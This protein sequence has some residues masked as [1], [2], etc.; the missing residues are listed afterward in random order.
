MKTILR[1][2]VIT[3]VLLV[4][5][6]L[7]V[8]APIML[9]RVTVKAA[10]VDSAANTITSTGEGKITVTPDVAY[11]NLGVISEGKNLSNTKK[12]NATK[13]AKIM[14]SLKDLGI[15]EKDIKT[16]EYSVNPK[17][18]YNEK[19]GASSINGY[20][21]SNTV[22]VTVVDIDKTDNLLD[23]VVESGSNNIN[24]II[25][26]VKDEASIYNQALELAV[27][28]AKAKATAMGKG[29][30]ITNI[31]PSKITEVSSPSYMYDT[32]ME[33]SYDSAA[34]NSVSKGTLDVTASVS[35][36]FSFK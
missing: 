21:V 11:V 1:S 15:K 30:G 12:D 7:V 6:L 13:M 27:K 20:T 4:L 3:S 9:N 8:S 17:Y 18:T 29:L 5:S 23:K 19:T 34:G 25:F 26:G 36:D 32:K 22:Q 16:V 28:D 35:V 14:T 10:S 2:K 33:A 31:T 24:G